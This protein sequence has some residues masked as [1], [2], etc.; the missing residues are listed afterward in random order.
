MMSFLRS[1][2]VG[3]LRLTGF[4]HRLPRYSPAYWKERLSQLEHSYYDLSQRHEQLI[5]KYQK[6]R[7][8]LQGLEQEN[9]QLHR[10]LAERKEGVDAQLES[11]EQPLRE[12]AQEN[13]Q[14]RQL[15][16]QLQQ[17][18]DQLQ[19]ENQTLRSSCAYFEKC[20]IST[21]ERYASLQEQHRL[22]E[23]EHA[24]L[25]AHYQSLQ[26][27]HIQL[28]AQLS[29]HRPPGLT[30]HNR[31]AITLYSNEMDFYPDETYE[32]ILRLIAEE[33]NR[34]PDDPNYYRRRR[35]LLRSLL[36]CNPSCEHQARIRAQIEELF[37]NYTG[38]TKPLEGRLRE[39]GF[40]L[41]D[42]N[43]YKIIWRND[44]RYVFSFAKTPSDRRA[45]RNIARDLIHLLF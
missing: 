6:V 40:S 20:A 8:R 26:Q 5:Q 7:Q 21:E 32:L 24:Q 22:L 15:H 45:G 42:G 1:L 39:L 13:Q 36:D 29:H 9:E 19:H 23:Q 30:T 38:M 35:D 17:Q 34:L 43:H 37:S 25:Q 2:W 10:Q 31:N 11:T 4:Y 16:Q 41:N 12:S 28:Q 27:E 44:Q 3:M 33:M 18:L 14:L